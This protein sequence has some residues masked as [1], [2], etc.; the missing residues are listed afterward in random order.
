MGRHAEERSSKLVGAAMRDDEEA[1]IAAL[2]AGDDP[3]AAPG[4]EQRTALMW[5]A[6]L[7]CGKACRVLALYSYVDKIE[8]ELGRTAL[9]FAVRGLSAGPPRNRENDH[10]ECVRHLLRF[11]AA[12]NI[13]DKLGRTAKDYA[14]TPKIAKYLDQV[15]VSTQRGFDE[16]T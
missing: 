13:P 5:A 12:A 14:G 4:T 3:D 11:H 2:H 9:H 16:A 6:S 10:L 1:V 7:G 15:R 8:P